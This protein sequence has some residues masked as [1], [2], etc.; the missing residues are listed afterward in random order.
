[1]S[2]DREREI[3]YKYFGNVGLYDFHLCPFCK[4]EIHIDQSALNNN[5]LMFSK[6]CNH[7]KRISHTSS[8]YRNRKY[9]IKFIN[10]NKKKQIHKEK[11]K[12]SAVDRIELMQVMDMKGIIFEKSGLHPVQCGEIAFAIYDANY[13]NITELRDWLGE[14]IKII[15]IK[16]RKEEDLIAG[17]KKCERALTYIKVLK[18]LRGE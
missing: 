10:N 9:V 7:S 14:K 3:K 15:K 8:K 16:P 5:I 17:I 13:R 11:E 6:S 4:E 1:M 2:E 18:K 12:E